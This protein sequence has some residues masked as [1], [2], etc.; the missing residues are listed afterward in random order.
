M[1]KTLLICVFLLSSVI[2]FSQVKSIYIYSQDINSFIPLVFYVN[3]ENNRIISYTIGV[4]KYYTENE[5]ASKTLKESFSEMRGELIESG[6]HEVSLT[7][8][9]RTNLGNITSELLPK[10]DAYLL[11]QRV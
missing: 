4:D 1:K 8:Q 2:A 7:S 11:N 5:D 10:F 6:F 3:L 9:S